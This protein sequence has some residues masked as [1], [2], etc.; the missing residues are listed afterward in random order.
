[1]KKII[2][3]LLAILIVDAFAQSCDGRYQTEIYS[4]V[5]VTTV[6]YGAAPNTV[7]NMVTLKM[8]I[9]QAVGDTST[10]RPVV[11]FCFGGSF[12]AG[13]RTEN[14][15]V[16]FATSLAKRGFV[17]ASIDYRIAG[18]PLELIQ[19]KGMVKIVFSA[20]QDGKASIRYF[21]KNFDEGN[22]LGINPD[23]IFIGGTSAG[24]ILAINLAYM[25]SVNKLPDT[26]QNWLEEAGGLEGNSGSPGYCSYPNGVFSFAGAVG[27]TSYINANDVPFY[28]C[29][30]TG[31][32]TVL[33]NYGPPLQGFAPVNLYGSGDIATRLTNL[34][35]YNVLDTYSGGNHP[36]INA[37]S[38][39]NMDVTR[40]NLGSF[41]Y[42]I[43]DCNAGN[44]KKAIQQSCNEF[45][46]PVGI[47]A[48]NESKD[49]TI[50]PNPASNFVT[51]KGA[52][53]FEYIKIYDALGQLVF[54]DKINNS[55]NY[56]LEV[57]DF[58]PGLYNVQML[59]N[60]TWQSEALL[61]Q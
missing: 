30:A 49:W 13:S 40:D 22:S 15:L 60:L 23:N 4:Q 29:H 10:D 56:T 17:C 34:G 26:W 6:D 55:N 35:I 45:Y 14:N 19:E 51:V 7:G 53:N 27:D 39:L 46:I 41:L 1:M 5:D 25:D 20:I 28:S 33:Y 43:V 58:V 36:P 12:S 48:I 54:F 50:Y 59:S 32:Q 9:Y 44:Q 3:F 31:D 52:S 2:T 18:S 21:R 24:G 37:S 8:D 57:L 42:N 38:G 11:I 61:I 47:R 16:S